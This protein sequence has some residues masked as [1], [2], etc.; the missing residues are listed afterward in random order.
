MREATTVTLQPERGRG[1][2]GLG[3]Q[4]ALLTREIRE[5]YLLSEQNARD[6]QLMCARNDDV[7]K[8]IA[9]SIED[10]HKVNMQMHRESMEGLER[11]ERSLNEIRKEMRSQN[12]VRRFSTEALST[13]IRETGSESGYALRLTEE[14][15]REIQDMRRQNQIFLQEM[16]RENKESATRSALFK[17]G[18][19]PNE[20]ASAAA[21]AGAHDGQRRLLVLHRCLDLLGPALPPFLLVHVLLRQDLQRAQS[22]E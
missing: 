20:E 12:E 7:G 9:L 10:L 15:R 21:E 18:P 6:I 3:Q 2:E 22:A 13:E 8:S 11:S 17:E 4:G 1:M 14:I 5:M 19:V 16:R